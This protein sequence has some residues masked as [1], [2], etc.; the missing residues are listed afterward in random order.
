M[1][2]TRVRYV[3]PEASIPSGHFGSL[4]KY[5]PMG[6]VFACVKWDVVPGTEIDPRDSVVN[7]KHDLEVV[8]PIPQ[9]SR[10]TRPGIYLLRRG[11]RIEVA[12]I[13]DDPGGL[14]LIS[15]ISAF[16]LEDL[17]EEVTWWGPIEVS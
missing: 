15:G 12:V 6:S 8:T 16:L 3:G 2:E 13:R 5:D 1:S 4:V 9:C 7:Y 10:P 11:V 14:T 17:E